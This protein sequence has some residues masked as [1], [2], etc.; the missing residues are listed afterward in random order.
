M[1][2]E[3]VAALTLLRTE[4]L[5]TS[6]LL[7]TVGEAAEL[8]DLNRTPR[9]FCKRWRTRVFWRSH[10]MAALAGRRTGG[11]QLP[12]HRRH[13]KWRERLT[14]MAF[15]PQGASAADL[16]AALPAVRAESHRRHTHG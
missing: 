1:S 13:Q 15:R 7:L 16:A 9:L 11:E 5:E 10:P 12:G 2:S 14:W 8:L 3:R 4:Y 6:T